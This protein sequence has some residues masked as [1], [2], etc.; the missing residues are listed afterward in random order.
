[1]SPA[2]ALAVPSSPSAALSFRHLDGS[3]MV[4]DH[5]RTAAVLAKVSRPVAGDR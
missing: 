5:L 4:L 3:L 2:S 1:M